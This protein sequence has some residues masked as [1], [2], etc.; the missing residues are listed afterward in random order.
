MEDIGPWSYMVRTPGHRFKRCRNHETSCRKKRQCHPDRAFDPDS[1]SFQRN[2]TTRV[3]GLSEL[4]QYFVLRDLLRT[5]S[6]KV[7]EDK[8]YR[9]RDGGLRLTPLSI[10]RSVLTKGRSVPISQSAFWYL[11]NHPPQPSSVG[12]T[13]CFRKSSK[14]SLRSWRLVRT[15]SAWPRSSISIR[16]LPPSIR[17]RNLM[18]EFTFI[19]PRDRVS[20]ISCVYGM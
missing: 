9:S 12:R 1:Q 8:S 11:P 3:V 6:Q 19:T 4:A 14:L 17:L 13:P 15:A 20:S 18:N 2:T 10:R 7:R 5:G 16:R